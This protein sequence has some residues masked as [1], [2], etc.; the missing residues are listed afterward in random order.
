M[1]LDSE[2]V[3]ATEL[4]FIAGVSDREVNRLV[5]ERI[6]PDFLFKTENG[7]R[8]ALSAA[9][10]ALFYFESGDIL[11]A[12]TRKSVIRE[13]AGRIKDSPDVVLSIV[14]SNVV[15]EIECKAPAEPRPSQW[16]WRNIDLHV[17]WRFTKIDM[18]PFFVAVCQRATDAARASQTIVSDPEILGGEPVFAGTRVPIDTVLESLGEGMSLES[19]QAEWPFLSEATIDDARLYMKLY[20]R[21]GR[22]RGPGGEAGGWK[23]LTQKLI[24]PE[25]S[26]A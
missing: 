22:P 9:A 12:N 26:D 24:P 13:M 6:L 20:P 1:I 25:A 23:M 16:V 10:L 3:S 4:A 14:G 2:M 11:T 15:A 7:R 5:D 18:E 17:D 8:F 21:R 19:L